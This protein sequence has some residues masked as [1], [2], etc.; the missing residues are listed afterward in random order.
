MVAASLA[1]PSIALPPRTPTPAFTPC[2]PRY[3]SC[4]GTP[5]PNAGPQLWS[6]LSGASLAPTLSIPGQRLVLLF[7][8]TSPAAV[9]DAIQQSTLG[10]SCSKLPDF[11]VTTP[12]GAFFRVVL[13]GKGYRPRAYVSLL[14]N[15]F[16]S[17]SR[18][19]TK[20]LG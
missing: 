12:E 15:A 9:S 2:R 18:T 20:W 8:G 4:A 14:L 3:F 6:R 10:A 7:A 13:R 16:A 11:M 19:L 17:I 1:P 5:D